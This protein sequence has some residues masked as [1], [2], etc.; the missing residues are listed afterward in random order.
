M[1][2]VLRIVGNV[3]AVLGVLIC[4]LSG[5]AR[6]AGGYHLLGFETMTLYIGGI[7]IMVMA[8]LAKLQRI[9]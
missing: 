8:C 9:K 1:D 2:R 5:L 3:L 7:G 4:L 6:L